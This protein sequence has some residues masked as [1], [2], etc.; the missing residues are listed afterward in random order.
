[1]RKKQKSG[2]YQNMTDDVKAGFSKAGLGERPD[3]S[4]HADDLLVGSSHLY[5]LSR[6]HGTTIGPG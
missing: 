5:Y 4:L 6:E 2:I 3:S 1:M